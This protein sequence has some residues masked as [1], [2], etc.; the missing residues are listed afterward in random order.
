MKTG[1]TDDGVEGQGC[2]RQIG[3]PAVSPVVLSPP[4]DDMLCPFLYPSTFENSIPKASLP[5][6]VQTPQR[7]NQKPN[8]VHHILVLL[9]S[10]PR[11]PSH[12]R[13]VLY[14][15]TRLAYHGAGGTQLSSN[16]NSHAS[17]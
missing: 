15:D 9:D 3:I 4:G 11:E 2:N 8:K 16:I 7:A 5:G 6:H 1:P 17:Y 14:R 12:S 10:I 13:Q